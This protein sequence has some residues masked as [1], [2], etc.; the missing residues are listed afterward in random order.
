MGQAV[1]VSIALMSDVQTMTGT[2]L[3]SSLAQFGLAQPPLRLS[4]HV[5]ALRSI[6]LLYATP[7]TI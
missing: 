6:M 3:K 2:R 4:G 7:P 5:T 1:S